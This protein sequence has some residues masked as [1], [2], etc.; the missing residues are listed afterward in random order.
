M[1][2]TSKDQSLDPRVAKEFPAKVAVAFAITTIVVVGILAIVNKSDWWR[3]FLPAMV[4]SA[5]ATLLSVL[6]IRQGLKLELGKAVA[7]YFGGVGTRFFVSLIAGFVAVK[8]GGY[9]PVPTLLLMVAF[10]VAILVAETM[11]MVKALGSVKGP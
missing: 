9:P 7:A 8:I 3:G 6:I 11:A 1:E 2:M 10:Y 5:L 4:I